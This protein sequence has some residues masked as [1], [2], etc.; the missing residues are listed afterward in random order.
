MGLSSIQMDFTGQVSVNPRL[1]RI[2]TPD[3]FTTITTAGYLNYL[4]LEGQTILPTDFIF[5][6][7]NLGTESGIFTPSISN[8]IITLVSFVSNTSVHLPVVTGDFATFYNTQGEIQ[9]QGY[10]PSNP[11][12][13]RVVMAADATVV[14]DIP[15]FADTTGSITNAAGFKPSNASNT[16][17]VTVSGATTINDVALFA[18]TAG[19]IKDVTAPGTAT[20]TI[21]GTLNLGS[22]ANADNGALNLYPAAAGEG[23]VQLFAAS[24]AAGNFETG[25]VLGQVGQQTAFFFTD[26]GQAYG[27]VLV[28][29]G[30][31][32]ADPAS[33]L[34]AFNVTVGFAALATGGT[35]TLYAS[36]GSKQ[37]RLLQLYMNGHGTNFSGGG[38]DRLL[39]ITD[40]TT[41]YSVVPATNLQTLLN[42]GW[43]ISTPLPFPASV[44]I[45]TLTAAGA[46]LV[47]KYSGGT[48]DYTAGSVVFTGLL[49]RVA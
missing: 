44:A 23:F 11:A 12:L 18:D 47:A 40:S 45:D 42:A 13:T 10:L 34:I 1:G 46:S 9:D 31:Q 7:Y 49:Q 30:N 22:T 3:T 17:L 28:T 4:N 37:Y 41:V 39:A 20:A 36:S 6:N 38:G 33:N 2:V 32:S 14:G 43:G 5:I 27:T 16:N 19:T 21:H 24:N 15:S 26:P 29:P 35:V 25:I 48:T 8:G